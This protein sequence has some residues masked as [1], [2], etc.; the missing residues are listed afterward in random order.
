MARD[1]DKEAGTRLDKWLWAARFFKT[2]SLATDAID[3][4]HVR[5]GGDRAKPARHLKVGEVLRVLTA[6]DEYEITVL[7][8][9]DKR[10]PADAARQLYA[11]TDASQQARAQRKVERALAPT[12]DHPDLKGRPSKKLRRQLDA[13]SRGDR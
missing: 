10:G 4:G 2:R 8:L 6:G 5:I 12:F 1:E 3:A 9:S 11:E 13:F 7:A